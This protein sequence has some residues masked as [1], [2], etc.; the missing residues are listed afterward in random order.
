[1]LSLGIVSAISGTMQASYGS[2]E[3]VCVSALEFET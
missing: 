3:S 1:M 2:S